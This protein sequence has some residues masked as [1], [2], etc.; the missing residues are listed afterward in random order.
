MALGGGIWT[1]QNKILPGT[2]Q[3]F[4]SA[5]VTGI[6]AGDRGV[7]AIPFTGDWGCLLYTSDAA[8]E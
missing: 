7:C 8:D 3:N 5:K 6:G 2:Y 4:V 1:S